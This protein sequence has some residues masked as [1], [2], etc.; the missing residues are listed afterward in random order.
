M[1]L[2][3]GPASRRL[4]DVTRALKGPQRNIGE[5]V[6]ALGAEGLGL[7]LLVLSL[8]AVIPTPGPIGT[9]FGTLI[10]LLAF[11]IL[12][13]SDRLWLPGR[14][15]RRVAP[16]AAIRKTIAT[17]LPWIGRVEAVLREDRMPAFTGR[18]ARVAF[19]VPI[20]VMAFTIVLPIPLG[21]FAP[22]VALVVIAMGFIAHDGLA[23]LIGLI[24]TVVALG[25]TA[26]LFV[27]GAEVI[28]WLT[29]LVGWG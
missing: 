20:L 17:A 2:P 10:A 11:Q 23:V 5:V 13:G 9:I 29:A 16:R 22:A 18:Q 12:A 15:R 1:T 28:G 26:V 25:W 19:A 4:I 8:P 6:D 27:F 14:L 7:A 21:N 3:R 24:G